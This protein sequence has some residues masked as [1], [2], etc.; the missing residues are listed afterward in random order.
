M[1]V[2]TIGDLSAH[3]SA[4]ERH[5]AERGA[6]SHGGGVAFGIESISLA[7]T[8]AAGDLVRYSSVLLV[9]IHA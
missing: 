2:E 1:F 5:L 4:I 3:E 7:T 6:E 9:Q 8:Q